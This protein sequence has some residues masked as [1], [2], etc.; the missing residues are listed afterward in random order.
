MTTQFGPVVIGIDESEPS[1][2][3]LKYAANL[4]DALR[5]ELVAVH[6]HPEGSEGYLSTSSVWTPT[7]IPYLEEGKDELDKTVKREV[8]EL[9]AST[10]LQ[11]R[12]IQRVG[13]RAGELQDVASEL[14]ASMLVV[15]SR[16]RGLSEML[17]RLLSGS[18]SHGALHYGSTPVL[19]VAASQNEPVSTADHTAEEGSSS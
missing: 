13:D 16:G 2:H 3:A 18:V 8:R 7:M 10:T 12:F 17:H 19:I 15:G 11:W 9:L 1:L 4:A 14:G 5:T 6:V